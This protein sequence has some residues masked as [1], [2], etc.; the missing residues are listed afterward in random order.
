MLH[1]D[2]PEGVATGYSAADFAG[3]DG[4]DEVDFA[5]SIRCTRFE[6]Q[7]GAADFGGVGSAA[8]TAGFG[9]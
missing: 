2:L 6:V 1:L 7:A 4:G 5:V 3:V 8:G 9:G